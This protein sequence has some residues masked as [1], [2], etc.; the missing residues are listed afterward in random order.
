M[1]EREI[2]EHGL[3]G[4]TDFCPAPFES[5]IFPVHKESEFGLKYLFSKSIHLYF[6]FRLCWVF[7]AARPALQPW[8]VGLSLQAFPATAVS[9]SSRHER[10]EAAAPGL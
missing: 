6:Y 8:C 5:G 9:M 1:R 3:L 10:P 7:F 2:R 4:S